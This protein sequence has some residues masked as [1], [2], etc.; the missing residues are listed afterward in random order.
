MQLARRWYA[1]AGIPENT[2]RILIDIQPRPDNAPMV[3][4]VDENNQVFSSGQLPT[5]RNDMRYFTRLTLP[6]EGKHYLRVQG[7]A[8]RTLIL[9]T[10][11]PVQIIRIGL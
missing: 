6:R 9:P 4:L 11:A 10:H 7:A 3:E 5:S 1:Q 8:E 2:Q